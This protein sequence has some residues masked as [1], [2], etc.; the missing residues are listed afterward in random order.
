MQSMCS[1]TLLF[2]VNQDNNLPYD[3]IWL[4]A[5]VHLAK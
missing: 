1:S 2:D 4:Q 3:I 5:K